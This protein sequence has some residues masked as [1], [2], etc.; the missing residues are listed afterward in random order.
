MP[1]APLVLAVLAL[2]AA[3]CSSKSRPKSVLAEEL[4]KICHAVERSGGDAEPEPANRMAIVAMWLDQNVRS[5]EGL[6]WLR[7]FSRL[8]EDKAARKKMLEDA[9][10][11]HGIADC[12]L[13]A[14][15][16]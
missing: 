1:R 5:D 7:T 6:E 2:A 8:G 11:A 14:F 13:L 9:A 3:G 10:R 16:Q 4:D 15:W 12:P